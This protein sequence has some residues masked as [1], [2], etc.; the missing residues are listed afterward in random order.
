MSA[1]LHNE[2]FYDRYFSTC[3][4]QYE[5][6]DKSAIFRAY[7]GLYS[8]W[9]PK[10]KNVTIL[11]LGA[12]LGLLVA[13]LR[14]AGFPNVTG[15]EPSGE[16]CAAALHHYDIELVMTKDVKGYLSENQHCFDVVFLTDVIE[17]VPKP[18]MPEY[19]SNIM[20]ALKP[21]GCLNLRTDNMAS[22]IGAYQYR[23]DFTHEYC[24]TERSLQQ[25]LSTVGF[26]RIVV[27]GERYN[28]GRRPAALKRAIIRWMWWRVLE[29][30]YEAE[31]PMA[32]NPRIF[33]KNLIAKCY[34]PEFA[35]S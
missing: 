34:R 10:E 6:P 3:F 2:I 21:G 16:Q 7:E 22:P 15:V 33:S 1:V 29:Q 25:L 17:H 20:Q 28:V 14:N 31:R 13:W 12:G 26:E 4:G 11:D 23:M 8:D 18:H 35:Y 30:L 5:L 32:V 9:L 24:F 19:L 27:R